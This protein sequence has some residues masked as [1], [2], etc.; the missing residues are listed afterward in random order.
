MEG[1]GI[2]A[3]EGDGIEALEGDGIKALEGDGIEALDGDGIEALEG[4]SLFTGV[5]G[6]YQ[7]LTMQGDICDLIVHESCPRFAFSPAH[8]ASPTALHPPS[9]VVWVEVEALLDVPLRHVVVLRAHVRLRPAVQRL[10]VRRLQLQHLAGT[11]TGVSV[12]VRRGVAGG[13]AVQAS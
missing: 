11:D 4:D 1:D 7:G 9:P 12:K 13:P 10:H 3:L 6:V 2:E 8:L 5:L